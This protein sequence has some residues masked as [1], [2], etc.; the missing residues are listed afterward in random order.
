MWVMSH[1]SILCFVPLIMLS[2]ASLSVAHGSKWFS[3]GNPALNTNLENLK[4]YSFCSGEIYS[5]LW[6]L[7]QQCLVM[8]RKYL[9]GFII[10]SI[11]LGKL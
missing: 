8:F 11:S 7:L 2:C 10:G 6:L 4:T 3:N 1:Q 5:D 9:I